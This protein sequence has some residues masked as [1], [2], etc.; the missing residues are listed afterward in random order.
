M[1]PLAAKQF[2]SFLSYS[3]YHKIT[4]LS[5]SFIIHF[6]MYCLAMLAHTLW[7]VAL[8]L[9]LKV[10]NCHA[11]N[12]DSRLY[13][14]SACTDCVLHTRILIQYSYFKNQINYEYTR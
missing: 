14:Q 12:A 9:S 13:T 6:R 2:F 11:A 5:T 4:P 1:M 10:K 3:L 7:S 8:S